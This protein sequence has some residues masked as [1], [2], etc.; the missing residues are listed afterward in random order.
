M[1]RWEYAKFSSPSHQRP[2]WKWC[3][4]AANSGFLADGSLAAH[5]KH[6]SCTACLR[7]LCCGYDNAFNNMLF[8][9]GL[10][11]LRK[12]SERVIF[13][14]LLL[15]GKRRVVFTAKQNSP[16]PD[17]LLSARGNAL[18]FSFSSA[19]RK[20]SDKKKKKLKTWKTEKNK[21]SS[22]ISHWQNP[23]G[24]SKQL[25]LIDMAMS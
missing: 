15:P 7:Q 19:A 20:D 1:K 8:S 24:V 12:Q 18:I 14:P 2:I 9:L 22:G 16:F 5:Y 6:A 17:K 3:P 21:C 4:Q 25:L 11:F 10:Y 23:F 13:S